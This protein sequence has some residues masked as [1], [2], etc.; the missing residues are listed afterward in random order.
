MAELSRDLRVALEAEEA[1]KHGQL[2]R[3]K[4]RKDLETLRSSSSPTAAAT[5]QAW[6][7][8]LVSL[9]AG[10][11]L[12]YASDPEGN[13]IADFSYAGYHN[14]ERRIPDVPTVETV[15]PISGD[16]TSHIQGA[17]D[18]VGRRPLGSDGLRGAVLLEAGEYEVAGTILLNHS[19]VVL[20]GVGDGVDPANHTVLR[21]VGNRPADRHVIV[22]GSGLRTRWT[23]EV[24][25]TRT[26]ITSPFVP[27]G[28]QSFTVG[29]ADALSVGDNVI[30]VHQI[31][32]AHV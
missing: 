19:G 12:V 8:E 11:K 10:G 9:D 23:G 20:R 29:S 25:G 16:N 1:G 14:S 21:A 4:R 6:A 18:A 2:I 7:S 31:G 17:I 28:S 26:N 30:I 15:R 3:R 27:V 22:A 32:R 24:S 13:R 5:A